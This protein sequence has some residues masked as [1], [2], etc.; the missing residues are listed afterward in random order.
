MTRRLAA[1]LLAAGLVGLIVPVAGPSPVVGLSSA[2][3][4]EPVDC[5]ESTITGTEVVADSTTKV[6]APLERMHV[7]QAHEITDGSEVGV[8][9]IDS[10]VQP[11]LGIKQ[12]PVLRL[13]EVAGPLLSG[14]GTIVAALIA[15]PEGVAPGAE[16][17]DV[18]VFDSAEADTTEGQKLVTSQGITDGIYQ[19]IE[20]HPTY[21]FEV[22]NISLSVGEDDPNLRQ[23]IKKL[24]GLGVVV[25]ASSSNV[26]EADE[27][28]K[29]TPGND[30]KV[31]PADYKGVLAVSAAPPPGQSPV[32][33]VRPNLDIDVAAPTYGAI[34]INDN[35]V[36]CDVNQ[37][38]TS[39]AA[40]EVSGVVALLRSAYPKDTAKQTIARLMATT[41]GSEL[42]KSPWTGAGV[43]QAHDALS[44]SLDPGR[45]GRIERSVLHDRGDA[46]A[47][48][49][50][51]RLD[52]FGSSRALVLWCGLAGGALMALAFMLRSLVRR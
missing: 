4:A 1:S 7:P 2:Y 35:G 48:L 27:D 49:P 13:P 23:A 52:L 29:G 30:A 33:L 38:A 46:V 45:S 21:P 26:P 31:Y 9:V 51:A 50:P 39:W 14:H 42:A 36:R 37:V 11:G 40:A 47:P 28:Y 20:L 10:G 6:N 17:I 24:Q 18:R 3:A 8:V 43:V 44:R 22:V 16:V 15:G 25:V 41:E 5:L 12:G 34:S 19:A 32:G